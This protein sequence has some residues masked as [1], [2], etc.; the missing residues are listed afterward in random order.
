[1]SK[2]KII[3]QFFPL[4]KPWLNSLEYN[5]QLLEF[6]GTIWKS[7]IPIIHLFVGIQ[8]QICDSWIMS[9]QYTTTM[10]SKCLCISA[11]GWHKNGINWFNGSTV[12]YFAMVIREWNELYSIEY[13]HISIYPL[14]FYNTFFACIAVDWSLPRFHITFRMTFV[15]KLDYFYLIKSKMWVIQCMAQ[16]NTLLTITVTNVQKISME[17]TFH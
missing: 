12:E 16:T 4:I 14:R 1:M 6:S 13:A 11:I 5:L 7:K 9:V 8:C 15:H 10:D 17:Y 3:P 2:V